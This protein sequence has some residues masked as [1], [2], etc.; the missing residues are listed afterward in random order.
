MDLAATD[1][2][3]GHA[4]GDAKFQFTASVWRSTSDA[5]N[6]YLSEVETFKPYAS[7][8]QDTVTHESIGDQATTVMRSRSAETMYITIV[9]YDNLVLS[10]QLILPRGSQPLPPEIF[11]RGIRSALDG[12]A[13]NIPKG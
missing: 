3:V 5:R 12:I 13:G 4:A 9:S 2:H 11:S 6:D 7:E 1:H 8:K 10:S